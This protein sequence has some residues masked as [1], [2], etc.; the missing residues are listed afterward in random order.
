M[1]L[2]CPKKPLVFQRLLVEPNF[3]I[4][5][6]YISL[7]YCH[8]FF[9]HR[10]ESIVIASCIQTCNC[11]TSHFPCLCLQ[12]PSVMLRRHHH[13]AQGEDRVTNHSSLSRV[14]LKKT[15][16]GILGSFGSFATTTSSAP[17]GKFGERFRDSRR[18]SFRH[19]FSLA[20]CHLLHPV[21]WDQDQRHCQRH[22][23]LSYSPRSDP[24]L[25]SRYTLLV[26]CVSTLCCYVQT[27]S[28]RNAKKKKNTVFSFA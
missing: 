15:F 26:L 18:K 21:D 7:I 19:F 13:Q 9:R 12:P 23:S 5:F 22:S 25:W 20:V 10:Q 16:Q 17:R 27:T 6:T 14:Y 4:D 3:Q 8:S 11:W 1:Y 2:Y 24:Y 28:K